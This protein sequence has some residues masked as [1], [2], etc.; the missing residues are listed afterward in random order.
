MKQTKGSTT[1][2]FCFSMCYRTSADAARSFHSQHGPSRSH[3]RLTQLKAF[4]KTERDSAQAFSRNWNLKI[5]QGGIKVKTAIRNATSNHNSLTSAARMNQ[6]GLLN[7]FTSTLRVSM[8][9]RLKRFFTP[10]VMCVL[11][12]VAGVGVAHA[13]QVTIKYQTFPAAAVLDSNIA[14][15]L[16]RGLSSLR[17]R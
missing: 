15:A 14:Q 8:Q 4:T 2:P 3:F 17:Q 7:N 9:T 12:V 10:L 1:L 16:L 5:N 6:S 11:A 13:G